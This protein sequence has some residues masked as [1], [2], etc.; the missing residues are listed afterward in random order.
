MDGGSSG[1]ELCLPASKR[2]GMV[3]PPIGRRGAGGGLESL[4]SDT[5]ACVALDVLYQAVPLPE[6]EATVPTCG[7]SIQ[8]MKV[9]IKFFWGSR[10]CA[11]P[12]PFGLVRA[13]TKRVKGPVTFSAS[14]C[15]L[16]GALGYQ[17]APLVGS[18]NS[19]TRS[20]F[21]CRLKHCFWYERDLLQQE[22]K[23]LV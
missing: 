14:E 20:K 15:S 8:T 16:R 10:C 1:S 3:G 18:D 2:V 22:A 21:P 23:P 19:Q 12:M 13:K 6:T 4:T 5:L 7:Q 11:F 9:T 17:L